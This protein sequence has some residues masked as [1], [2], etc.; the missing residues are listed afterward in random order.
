MCSSSTFDEV[1]GDR[2]LSTALRPTRYAAKICLMGRN[3]AGKITL[4]SML[5]NYPGLADP[6]FTLDNGAVFW[7]LR[8]RSATSAG[9]RDY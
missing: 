9:R 4:K 7:G 6:E 1:Y 3:G 2:K 8:H 5:A